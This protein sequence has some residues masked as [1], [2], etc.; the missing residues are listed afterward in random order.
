M[1]Y[2]TQVL[3]DTG[4]HAGADQSIQSDSVYV[5]NWLTLTHTRVQSPPQ[6]S[7]ECGPVGW[8]KDIRTIGVW[9]FGEYTFSFS[10]G[11]EN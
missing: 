3:D 7:V 2:N 5:C 6:G 4:K 9:L 1:K 8:E 10:F 11:S